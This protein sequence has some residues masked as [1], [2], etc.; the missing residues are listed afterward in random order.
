MPKR[1]NAT[2]EIIHK[3]READVL[4]GQGRT[5]PDACKQLGILFAG[6]LRPSVRA[7][8]GG[9]MGQASWV[10][11]TQNRGGW[12]KRTAW[13]STGPA[14]PAKGDERRKVRSCGQSA[15]AGE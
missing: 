7:Q 3:L 11:P 2:E 9:R 14:Q 1:R 8:C 6:S 5:V 4:L 13:L 10:V 15:Y 12:V